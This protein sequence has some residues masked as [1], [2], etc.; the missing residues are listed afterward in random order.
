MGIIPIEEEI[1]KYTTLSYR[2]VKTQYFIFMQPFL[3]KFLNP[4]CFACTLDLLPK[5]VQLNG[6]T[7]QVLKNSLTVLIFFGTWRRRKIL[8]R[9]REN[10]LD[11]LFLENGFLHFG[12]VEKYATISL[13]KNILCA[14]PLVI[15]PYFFVSYAEICFFEWL[16][17]NII[18]DLDTWN[19]RQIFRNLKYFLFSGLRKWLIFILGNL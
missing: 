7:L 19:N 17:R 13:K 10:V 3:K 5:W 18:N 2:F 16:I 6:K 1:K 14:N 4:F 12:S 15:S 8:K 9:N 11:D